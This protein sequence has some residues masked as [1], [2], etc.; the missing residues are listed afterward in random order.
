M[1]ITDPRHETVPSFLQP[2][3]RLLND[4]RDTV[5]VWLGL[6]CL[7]LAALGVALFFVKVPWLVAAPLYWAL[8]FGALLDRFTLMLHCTSHRP[9]FKKRFRVLN[10]VIPWVLGPFF[11]QTPNTY[12]AH[13]MGMHHRE[14][15][16]AADLSS[17]MRFKRDR[18]DHWL[19]YCG[20]FMVIGLFE[21]ELYFFRR[22]Q[23]KLFRR[24]LL[25]EGC[26]WLTMAALAWFKPIPT[27]VVFV[28]P[29]VA[30]RSM[31]MMGNWI[32]HSFIRAETPENPYHSSITCINTRYNR[33]C[34]NDGY[35]ILHHVKPACHWS[36]HPAE[37][38][39]ALRDYA[40]HDAIVF[41]GVDYFQ[42]WILLM[43]RRWSRLATHFV[44]LEG[45]PVRTPDQVITL[46]KERVMPV[47]TALTVERN[48]LA[49]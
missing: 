40:R 30:I 2:T 35:H 43:A 11:G 34:F 49:A 22:R 32:Q 37:F 7:T 19:R 12:F 13:H 23:W 44:R 8:L 10:N 42:I 26:Y 33:R 41:D 46:L 31:M 17:T 21:L 45:A 47:R 3:A 27:V 29:L 28:G 39:R 14:E 9:L 6:R 15:N 1:E 20:R 38:E 18:V 4:T 48:E 16:L 24:V 36:E 5:F 25:G